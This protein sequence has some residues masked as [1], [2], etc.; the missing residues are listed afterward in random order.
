MPTPSNE[1]DERYLQNL[2][3]LDSIIKVLNEEN[4]QG[5]LDCVLVERITKA[6]FPENNH[7]EY[8]ISFL[9][10]SKTFTKDGVAAGLFTKEEGMKSFENQD[11]QTQRLALA[12][13]QNY[14]D[15]QLQLMHKLVAGTPEKQVKNPK[16]N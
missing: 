14:R 13:L 16:N 2:V 4:E 7:R 8:N 10:A 1:K 11:N 9:A 15:E 3:R 5:K 6:A 12:L